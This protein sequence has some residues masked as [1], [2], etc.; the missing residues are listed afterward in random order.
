MLP[1]KVSQAEY[2]AAKAK[3]AAGWDIYQYT[4]P[5][6][7]VVDDAANISPEATEMGLARRRRKPGRLLGGTSGSSMPG[8]QAAATTRKPALLGG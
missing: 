4:E 8:P 6:Y 1:K 5:Q 3:L 2:D 7:M